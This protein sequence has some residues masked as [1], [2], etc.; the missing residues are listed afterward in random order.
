M[1]VNWL[2]K[3]NY[4]RKR[5]SSYH[6]QIFL[7]LRRLYANLVKTGPLLPP[8]YNVLKSS[9]AKLNNF[10][11]SHSIKDLYICQYK[12]VNHWN[13]FETLTVEPVGVRFASCPKMGFTTEFSRN[14]PIPGD[15]SF[16]RCVQMFSN[17]LRI[18]TRARWKEI[19]ILLG[20]GVNTLDSKFRC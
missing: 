9:T 10:H 3:K 4:K 8:D 11:R 5:Y 7:L 1:L 16:F 19:K 17:V 13:C 2:T 20:K 14:L 12:Y 6:S 15:Q 18:S